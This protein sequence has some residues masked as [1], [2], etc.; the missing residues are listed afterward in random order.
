MCS[1]KRTPVGYERQIR[2][3]LVAAVA[4][5]GSERL[6]EEAFG[7][8]NTVR[9]SGVKEIDP[10]LTRSLNRTGDLVLVHAAPIA[11][12]DAD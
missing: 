4:N 11:A 3:D 1:S 9:L 12:R 10:F 2:A 7:R 5:V 8:L 6:S